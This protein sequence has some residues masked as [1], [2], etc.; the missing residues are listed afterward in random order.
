MW[1]D[2]WRSQL[3]A[4][5]NWQIKY[6]SLQSRAEGKHS[7]S[8]ALKATFSLLQRRVIGC[9]SQKK[10]PLEIWIL[11]FPSCVV[12]TSLKNT[13][14]FRSQFCIMAADSQGLNS[15]S[16]RINVSFWSTWITIPS[17]LPYYLWQ[18]A[19]MISGSLIRTEAQKWCS[20]LWIHSITHEPICVCYP[21]SCLRLSLK[22]GM[23]QLILQPEEHRHKVTPDFC[24][25]T[26][27]GKNF[28]KLFGSKK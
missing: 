13:D 22:F 12:K 3:D 4:W 1:K 23:N 18:E 26:R 10:G 28:L 15:D 6:H 25:A 27:F 19:I 17:T 7:A 14:M 2:S 11:I 9:R 21:M 8:H 24:L 20:F 5:G 16:L